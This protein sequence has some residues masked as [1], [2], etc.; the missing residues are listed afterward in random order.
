VVLRRCE[1]SR[2]HRAPAG[3]VRDEQARRHYTSGHLR[4]WPSFIFHLPSGHLADQM[5]D[6]QMAD[7]QMADDQMADDQM[8]DDQMV[9]GQMNR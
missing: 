5:A 9:D 4:I 7:D 8:A 3:A 2:A 1:E 6:D